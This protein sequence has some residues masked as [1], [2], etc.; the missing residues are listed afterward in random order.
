MAGDKVQMEQSELTRGAC[1]WDAT[2]TALNF[3]AHPPLPGGTDPASSAAAGMAAD[4]IPQQAAEAAARDK[5]ALSLVTATDDTVD[6]LA[7]AD[8]D[9]AKNFTRIDDR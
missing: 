6:N 5:L 4:W 1:A 3:D 2:A 9:A 8:D 7:K